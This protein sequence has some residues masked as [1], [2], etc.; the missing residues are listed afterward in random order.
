V[1]FTSEDER[2]L[3][4]QSFW[5][6]RCN[7]VVVNFGTNLP[8]IDASQAKA[9]FLDRYPNLRNKRFLVFLGRIHEK[10]GCDILL[11][12]F[13]RIANGNSIDLVFAGP[14]QSG[15]QAELKLLA[16]RLGVSDR[17]TW[18]GMLQGPEKW[19]AYYAADA[20]VLPSHSENFGIA[21]VEALACGLPVLISKKVNIWREI[22]SDGAGLAAPDDLE[23]TI[24]LLVSWLGMPRQQQNSMR[25]RAK[26]SF[27]ARFDLASS[28]S[29]LT[30]VISALLAGRRVS[31]VK[32]ESIGAL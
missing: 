9:Q 3:A 1:L 2:L 25:Y 23:G 29:S 30:S 22:V 24:G 21:V 10:K 18:T 7:E 31:H 19:G 11:Q 14:D 6:Y 27:A 32:E 20:F 16:S 4:R 26:E 15:W 8:M 12:A 5:L 13:A 28:P 17:V